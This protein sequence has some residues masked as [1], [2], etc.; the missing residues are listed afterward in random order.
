MPRKRRLPRKRHLIPAIAL[1]AGLL[2]ISS[3]DSFNS[4]LSTDDRKATA[5]I[6]VKVVVPAALRITSDT[7]PLT[8]PPVDTQTLTISAQQQMML[9]STL[10]EGFCMNLQLTQARIANWQ[11]QVSGSAGAW[12][13]PSEGG[14]R[15]CANRSGHYSLLLQHTFTLKEDSRESQ[16]VA[17][18]WPV[19][20]SLTAP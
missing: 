18:A 5:G 7:H 16:T 9:V 17:L 15:L 12:V 2:G 3:Y 8:L 4:S 20:M 1:G 11:V 14:Y 19:S 13:E 10:R 6:G